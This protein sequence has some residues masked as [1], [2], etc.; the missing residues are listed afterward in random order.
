MT[1]LIREVKDEGL[2]SL[3]GQEVCIFCVNYI[4]TGTLV[5][6][7]RIC[8]LLENPAIVYETGNLNEKG[9]KDKQKFHTDKWYVKISAI[10]SFGLSK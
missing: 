7:N 3:L 8:I 2:K 10:E 1:K 9:Y 5:G 4:Y 6:I